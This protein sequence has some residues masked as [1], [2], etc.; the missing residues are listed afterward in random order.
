MKW[1]NFFIAALFLNIFTSA[2]AE[3]GKDFSVTVSSRFLN[4]YLIVPGAVFYN[5]SVAQPD[6]YLT[7]PKGFY[8]DLWA[9]KG[10][11]DKGLTGGDYGDEIDYTAGIALKVR[12]V[13][14]DIGFSYFDIYKLWKPDGDVLW[15][16]VKI[17]RTFSP[18]KSLS[19]SPCIELDV[20]KTIKETNPKRGEIIIVSM[21][22]MAKNFL[23]NRLNVKQ[24]MGFQFDSGFPVFNNGVLWLYNGSVNWNTIVGV[25]VEFPFVR[26][27]IPL[28]DSSRS[29]HSVV[30]VGISKTFAF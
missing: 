24:S 22:M 1:L 7:F 21:E 13:N 17:S 16:Y 14:F 23:G 10:L 19:L 30:G 9:S 28:K 18:Q 3:D 29:K 8:L 5:R 26:V 27:K 20:V 6:V 4:R 12:E 15:P 25:N 2:S 11:D